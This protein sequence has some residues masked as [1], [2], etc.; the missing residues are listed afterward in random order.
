MHSIVLS[1][2]GTIASTSGDEGATP[3][4]E[5][6]ELIDAVPELGDY[7]TI[8]VEEIAQV[9]SFEMDR[10]TLETI[11]HRVEE[12]DADDDIDAVIITHGTDTM[13]ETAY[14]LDTALQPETPVLLT[15][16]Q[17]RPDE[18]SPDGQSNLL[19][20]FLA[21]EAFD[22]H[23]GRGVFIA[24]NEEIH[25]ARSATKVHTSKLETFTSVDVGPVATMTH[26]GI[27]MHR[28]P[29]SETEHIPTS[30]M[31]GV[32]YTIASG[33]GVTGDLAHAA[34]EHGVDGFVING[35]GL[36]NV[37]KDLGNTIQ[38]CVQAGVPVVVASRCLEGQ[39][40]PV[41]GSVGGGEKLREYGALFAGDL[42]AQKA[43]IRLLLALNACEGDGVG[44]DR[45]QQIRRFFTD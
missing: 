43:R 45:I 21:A 2:G 31:D 15:G 8:D 3:T 13:E 42:S 6:T 36:G 26:D 25:A 22:D 33:I 24:F 32:V 44:E 17:R 16:A 38:E 1:T 5:G 41:Y 37:T 34:L 7:G 20:S 27:A 23:T 19:T 29:R 28:T 18:V 39:T 4:K 14:Y 40:S 12:L 35:T 10:E 11:G 30:S 9:P